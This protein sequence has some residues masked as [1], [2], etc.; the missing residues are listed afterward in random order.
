MARVSSA[1]MSGVVPSTTVYA[2]RPY[3]DMTKFLSVFISPELGSI[4]MIFR[5]NSPGFAARSA[6]EST[7]M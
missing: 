1:I 7:A 2:V 4:P 6:S 3:A 5:P